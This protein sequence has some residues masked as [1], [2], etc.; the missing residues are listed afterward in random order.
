MTTRLM[1]I[2]CWIPKATNTLSEYVI[3]IA[4]PGQ[5]RMHE[6]RPSVS[7][8]KYIACLVVIF[9]CYPLSRHYVYFWNSWRHLVPV[10]WV[11]ATPCVPS[12]SK[13]L[14]FLRNRVGFK[15]RPRVHAVYLP[16]Y[17]C[18][19]YFMSDCNT[20]RFMC[21]RASR[22]THRCPKHIELFRIINHNCCE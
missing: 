12:L 13:K 15:I 1:W 22:W 20:V 9:C 5:Q 6:R 10:K 4:V 11:E 18:D 21:D 3:L 7:R 19:T 8:Y 17:L 16:T 2:A 14:S